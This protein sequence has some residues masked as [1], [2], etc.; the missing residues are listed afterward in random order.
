MVSLRVSSSRT[1]D[2]VAASPDILGGTLSRIAARLA[3]KRGNVSAASIFQS[4]PSIITSTRPDPLEDPANAVHLWPVINRLALQGAEKASTMADLKSTR[5]ELSQIT[6]TLTA[7][8]YHL[9][10]ETSTSLR[11]R[12]G[13]ASNSDLSWL[14]KAIST[15]YMTSVKDYP[16]SLISL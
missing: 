1:L 11:I 2:I 14:L 12:S 9:S 3:T 5:Q 4:L 13:R 7:Q 10:S 8:K 16:Q 6:K 15:I